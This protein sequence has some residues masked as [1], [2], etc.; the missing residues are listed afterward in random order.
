M[1]RLHRIL[2]R[3]FLGTRFL[4]KRRIGNKNSICSGFT[5]RSA[6]RPSLDSARC[7]DINAQPRG[8]FTLRSALLAHLRR[9]E[10]S[11]INVN[12]RAFTLIELLIAISIL[13]L[14]ALA[15]LLLINPNRRQNQAKDATIKADVGQLSTGVQ[16]YFASQTGTY[17][18]TL[19]ELVNNGDLKGVPTPPNATNYVYVVTDSSGG[20]CDGINTPCAIARISNPLTDPV[21]AGNLW[22]WQSTTGKAQEL[23]PSQ[24]TP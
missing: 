22:C 2:R 15:V 10:L 12:A 7:S 16:A 24:C 21:D 17:P 5:L 11:D 9:A 1:K 20:A 4:A 3:V 23:A 13:G 19:D 6:G 18:L 8:G 14:L